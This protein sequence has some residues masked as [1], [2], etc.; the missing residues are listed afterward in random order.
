[1]A[2]VT[3]LFRVPAGKADWKQYIR[4]GVKAGHSW[5]VRPA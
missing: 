2:S 5:K 3:G 1:M 4:S